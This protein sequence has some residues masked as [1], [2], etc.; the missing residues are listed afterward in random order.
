MTTIQPAWSPPHRPQATPLD[1]EAYALETSLRSL[2][3]L[4]MSTTPRNQQQAIGAS[5]VGHPCDHKVAS[6]LHGLPTVNVRDLWPAFVGTG[7][8]LALADAFAR[9]DADSGRFLVEH[10]T[11]YR[12]VPGTCDVFDRYTGT[13]VD[14]KT[15]KLAR[16]KQIRHNGPPAPYVV[17]LQLYAAA[18]AAEGERVRHV[19]LAFLPVDGSLE[20]LWVWRTAYD[21]AVADAA[22][23]RL[24]VLRGVLPGDAPRR[25]DD[26]C[27]WCNYFRPGGTG[28][29]PG[30]TTGESNND[31]ALDQTQPT[32]HVQPEGQPG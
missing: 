30:N 31:H 21:Q 16:L 6:R 10:A 22:V 18:L 1:V 14:W 19:A 25:P 9:L 20:D 26:M 23:Q 11:S 3:Y 7:V 5:E 28:G 32:D 13:V 27:G 24:N 15:T 17:Q 4:G 2:L 29:C 12:D 8:H